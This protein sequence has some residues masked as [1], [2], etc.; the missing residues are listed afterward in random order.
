MHYIVNALDR[1][2]SA[3]LRASH[4]DAHRS[5]LEKHD[6]PLKVVVAGPLLSDDEDVIGSLL[7]IESDAIENVRAFV[8]TDPY[9]IAGVY[10]SVS[11]KP[12]RAVIG[13]IGAADGKG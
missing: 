6:F 2:G 12:F 7:I 9:W 13:E 4:R 11:V 3:S 8:G 1:P 10:E 5:R